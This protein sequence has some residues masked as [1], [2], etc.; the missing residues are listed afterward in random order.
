V[1]PETRSPAAI[2]TSSLINFLRLDQVKLLSLHP[3]LDFFVTEHV[4]D[5]VT[6]RYQA[7]VECLDAALRAGHLVETTINT[8]DELQTFAELVSLRRFGKGECAAIAA[9]VHRLWPIA[10]DDSNAIKLILRRYL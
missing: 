4:R 1:A 6:R 8:I 5:E 9:A 3:N 2:D 7:Q 10:L